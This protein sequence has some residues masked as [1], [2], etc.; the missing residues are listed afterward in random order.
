MAQESNTQN[1][2]QAAAEQ[3]KPAQGK[4]Q[5]GKSAK[6][7]K[8][9]QKGGQAKAQKAPRQPR[10]KKEKPARQTPAHMSKVEKVA[11]QLP[12]LSEEASVVYQASVNLSTADMNALVSHINVEIRR[13]SIRNQETAARQGRTNFEEGS[14]VKIVSGNPKFVGMEGTVTKKQRIRCYVKL[15]GRAYGTR[16]DGKA[17]GDY[18]FISDVAALGT[19][20]R[21]A[22]GAEVFARLTNAAPPATMATIED[23]DVNGGTQAATG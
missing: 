23:E 16:D 10:Q 18:F 22:N 1:G 13:R 7:A 2:T 15:D 19:G 17:V 14:R 11:A 8:A 4:G 3:G 5:Q 6:K 21:S 9:G 20:Q 12:Q